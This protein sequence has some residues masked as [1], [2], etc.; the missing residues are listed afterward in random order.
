MITIF[1]DEFQRFPVFFVFVALFSKETLD[2]R[3]LPVF[4]AV[5]TGLQLLFHQA[6]AFHRTPGGPDI[7][8]AVVVTELAALAGAIEECTAC[9]TI[10]T[11][12]ADVGYVRGWHMY[13][14]VRRKGDIVFGRKG[15]VHENSQFNAI[16]EKAQ[17]LLM[18]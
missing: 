18:E 15:I 17:F 14:N 8:F 9:T 5:G 6:A 10:R 12:A 7:A 13:V 2:Y 16:H 1:P 11:A 4:R 3:T